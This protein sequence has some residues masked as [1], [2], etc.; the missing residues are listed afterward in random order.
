VTSSS[1]G[2]ARA[3]DRAADLLVRV[4][5]AEEPLAFPELVEATGLPKSTVSR[6]LSSLERGGLIS[7]ADAGAVAPG[8]ALTRFA[9]GH[10][11]QDELRALARP[12]LER[13]GAETGET[14]N[15]AVPTPTGV[16]QIDQVD[17][18]FLLGAVNWVEREVPFHCSALGKALLAA[19]WPLPS[20]SLDR[21]TDRTVT[22]RA[23][24]DADI[25]AARSRG[26]AVADGEL[27]PGLVAI[28]AAV[29]D[30]GRPIAAM[31]VSGPDTR[32][33]PSH[34][35]RIGELLVQEARRLSAL[36]TPPGKAG[37]A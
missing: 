18:R 25:A 33:T 26:Y 4:L 24:L 17:P 36:L 32:L 2:G 22:T 13:L 30:G 3:V 27:E 1:T 34:T 16:V 10:R 19:G 29:I 31:S 11:W 5:D 23:A 21:M 28:A 12:S 15:L 20:A 6:L 7:R 9:R 14:I 35:R 37:A 8:P